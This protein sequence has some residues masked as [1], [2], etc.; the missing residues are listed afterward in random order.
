MTTL[1]DQLLTDQQSL[2]AVE[3]FSQKHTQ[4][5]TP[6]HAPLYR[7]L[8]PLSRPNK[9]QQYAFEVNLDS[10]SGCKAC[11]TACHSLNGLDDDIAWRDVGVL[12]GGTT[13]EPVQQTV[14]T[15]CHHC[16]DPACANGCPVLAYEKDPETGIVRHLDDQCIGCQYC[17]MKCPY[18]VPKYSKKRGIVRKCDMC[19]DRLAE[20]E[21]PACVQ[22]CP[23]EAIKITIVQTD[24]ITK[25]SAPLVP[26]AVAS[27][28][29]SPSTKYTGLKP[30]TTP[31]DQHT[32]TPAP[33]HYPLVVM[34]VLTQA[35]LG[36]QLFSG[37]PLLATILAAIG[38]AASALHLGQPTRAWR[39]FLGLRKSWLSR[40]AV[41]FGAW[42]PALAATNIPALQKYATIPSIALGI[43]GV[44]CS[45]MVYADTK[46][47]LW[48][49]D[50]SAL[51][52]FGTAA[53]IGAAAT[54]HPILAALLLITKLAFETLSI[55]DTKTQKLQT[56]PLKKFLLARY[57]TAALSIATGAWPLYLISELFARALYFQSVDQP[58][59]PGNI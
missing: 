14:T 20:G 44:F 28:Y 41:I 32:L 18:D 35:A 15:A 59:M 30:N 58:K 48:R 27:D 57:I 46:R 25:N 56:G 42:F 47:P 21:A 6:L 36:I 52:F 16:A 49:L 5:T 1:I 43:L 29:T 13:L 22:A 17:Q 2:T 24:E 19:Q 53:I 38:L 23:N 7:D 10:C 26:G 54:A 4:T 31:A 45:V 9:G 12:F 50:K 51:R 55:K 40:E 37:S 33:A 11:V 8:I 39:I 34:L 3:K